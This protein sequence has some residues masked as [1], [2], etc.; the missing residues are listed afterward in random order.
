[1][2][3]GD[4]RFENPIFYPF[5]FDDELDMFPSLDDAIQGVKVHG[6]F[7]KY[8]NFN[9]TFLQKKFDLKIDINEGPY[10]GMDMDYQKHN[11][12]M[13]KDFEMRMSFPHFLFL[14][15]LNLNV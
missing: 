14:N 5:D 4:D 2:K 12:A 3:D 10:N 7:E 6:I 9:G 13:V 15:M 11:D 8:D 1:M